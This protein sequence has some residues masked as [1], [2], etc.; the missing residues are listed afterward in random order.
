MIDNKTRALLN[1]FESD[2]VGR[3]IAPTNT[4]KFEQAI[5]VF[6]NE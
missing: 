2:R 4:S 5:Y 1:D 3:A 6:A